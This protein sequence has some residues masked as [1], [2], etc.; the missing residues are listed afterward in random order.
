MKT[1]RRQWLAATLFQLPAIVLALSAGSAWAQSGHSNFLKVD[2]RLIRNQNGTGDA[3]YLRGVN[4]GGWQVHEKWMSP[5]A[6]V[7]DD[8]NMRK[9]LS[10][11]FGDAGRDAL[12]AAYQDTYLQEKD[13]IRLSDLGM[14]AVRLPMRA[15]SPCAGTAS[16][17]AWRS[18]A[19]QPFTSSQAASRLG[20]W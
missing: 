14:S 7:N 5:L 9:T 6:G 20:W 8:Y 19:D 18:S 13:F 10:Q 15:A 2:G 16:R 12:I 3:V 1:A 11:R 4:L 17:S